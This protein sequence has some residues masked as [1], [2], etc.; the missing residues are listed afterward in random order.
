MNKI[1]LRCNLPAR[2]RM[3]P[4]GD[5]NPKKPPKKRKEQPKPTAGTPATESPKKK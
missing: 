2:E 4:M 1:Q 3:V 5:K